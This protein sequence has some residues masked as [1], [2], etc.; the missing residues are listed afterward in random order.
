MEEFYFI[1]NKSDK[2]PGTAFYKKAEADAA[3][4]RLEAELARVR[5]LYAKEVDARIYIEKL[6]ARLEAEVERL[7]SALGEIADSFGSTGEDATNFRE[8]AKKALSGGR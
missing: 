8:W 2:L 7:K 6:H 3:I 4:A 1:M 5:M